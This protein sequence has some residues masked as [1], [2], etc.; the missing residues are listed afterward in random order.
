MCLN[1]GRSMRRYCKQTH[2]PDAGKARTSVLSCIYN[3]PLV[4]THTHLVSVS[5][6]VYNWFIET[7]L[8]GAIVY[9]EG[10][11]GH[12]HRSHWSRTHRWSLHR[13]VGISN[14]SLSFFLS[15]LRIDFHIII[16]YNIQASSQNRMADITHFESIQRLATTLMSCSTVARPT[17]LAGWHGSLILYIHGPTG[18][19]SDPSMVFSS[20][21]ERINLVSVGREI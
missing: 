1:V 3:I 12:R 2:I 14:Q 19:G 9:N 8:W 4:I 13:S 7:Q 16:D 17:F 21:E 18:C 20:S 10:H 6:P 15:Q 5:S 11:A